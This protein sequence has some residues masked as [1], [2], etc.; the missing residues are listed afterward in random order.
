M[1]SRN[2]RKRRAAAKCQALKQ[3]VAEAFALETERRKT[4][5]DTHPCDT[6]ETVRQKGVTDRVGVIQ[7]AGGKRKFVARDEKP[8]EPLKGD[9]R[10]RRAIGY[11]GG[12][13]LTVK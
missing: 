7:S 1:A 3:A 10:E 2:E 13:R 8:L 9:Y 5:Y 4:S 6:Y 11:F 12:K